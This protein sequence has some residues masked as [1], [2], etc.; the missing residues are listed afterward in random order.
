[1]LILRERSM[2]KDCKHTLKVKRGGKIGNNQCQSPS[3]I[4]DHHGSHGGFTG[5]RG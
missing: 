5:G 2:A 4:H 1:M 3:S